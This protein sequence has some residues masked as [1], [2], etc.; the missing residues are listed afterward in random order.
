MRSLPGQAIAKL[1]TGLSNDMRGAS[2]K[3]VLAMH[4]GAEKDE[5]LKGQL[6]KTAAK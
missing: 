5:E 2:L 1:S 6:A 4:A 3:V